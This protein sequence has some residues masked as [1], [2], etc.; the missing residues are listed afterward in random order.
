MF[1]KDHKNLNLITDL[2]N[3]SKLIEAKKELI[4]LEDECSNDFAFYNIIAQICEKLGEIDEAIKNYI[5]SLDLNNNFFESK[6][7]LA[8]LYYKLKNLDKSEELFKQLIITNK[9][10]YYLYYNLGI[11]QFEKKNFSKAIF[12]LKNTLSIN[13]SFHLA[14][15]QLAMIYEIQGDSSLA[16]TNYQKAIELDTQGYSVSHV[17]LGNVYLTL[18]DYEKAKLSF[19]K[20]LTL[21]GKKSSIYFNLGIVHYEMN[22]ILDSLK[23]FDKAIN[24]DEKNIKFSSTLIGISHFLD[25]NISYRKKILEKYRNNIKIFSKGSINPFNYKDEVIKIGFLSNG[26]RKYPTGYFLL[27]F[28]KNL[29]KK[30][31][32]D[33]YAFSNSQF[34][35]EYTRDLRD[36]FTHWHDVSSLSDLEL[37]NLI[38][39]SGINFLI[40]MQG[41]TY[42]NRIQ[43]FASK[44]APVQLSWA[45]YLS[46][47]GIPEIDYIIGDNFVTPNKHKNNY[48]E[49]IWNL[50]NIWCVLSTSDIININPSKSPV[51]T[52]GFI[53][54]GC[55]NNVKKINDKLIESWSR[56]LVNLSDSKLFIKSDQ[57]V[58]QQFRK[59]FK[60]KFISL[61]VKEDQLIFEENSPREDLLKSYNKIDIALDTFPYSGGT[62]SL[63]LSFMCVPLVTIEGSDFISRC[64]V[65]INKN[66]EMHNLIASN[67]EEYEKIAID[68]A[69]D[70]NKLNSLRTK[71]INSSRS[72]VL[73]N[74]N[75]F[76][77]E[78][79][80]TI[81]QMW[82]IF[83]KQ[84]KQT[85]I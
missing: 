36:H 84:N 65:S 19:E 83:L 85:H 8:I 6:F 32:F 5:K 77:E 68:L 28:I 52:N 2:I 25:N 37:I 46:S 34:K 3:S 39:D 51:N 71:L 23:F 22:N 27:D 14:Y 81:K 15:H 49:N 16:I 50:K 80:S 58:N 60:K 70:L 59:I 35:D 61:G 82:I 56:I 41:H 30:N 42:D 64:G 69:K 12:F 54:F 78:F 31:Y 66:L 40:D 11:I 48:V 4:L 26:F 21:Q 63:E 75:K 47:T 38:R 43:I 45:S 18:K 67:F 44:P 24:L 62:T 13:N 9:Q 73:F 10:N 72:S 7:N 57:F 76:S 74:I 79:A 29:N 53:T 33:L 1:L 55:F 20:A 17:N